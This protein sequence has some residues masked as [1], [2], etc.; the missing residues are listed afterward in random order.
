MTSA[1]L[2]TTAG[3][4]ITWPEQAASLASCASNGS[5]CC[6]QM[7]ETTNPSLRFFHSPAHS[8]QPLLYQGTTSV[9]PQPHQKEVGFSPRV[10]KPEEARR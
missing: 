6:W 2:A 10:L 5:A 3:C 9:V 8:P 4:P 7:W 1:I